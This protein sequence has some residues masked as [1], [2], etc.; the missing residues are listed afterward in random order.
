MESLG[1][2]TG[3][4]IIYDA[5]LVTGKNSPAV[6][7][8]YES[9]EVLQQL[10]AG[11]NLI[12]KQI[13]SGYTITK[14]TDGHYRVGTLALT[15]INGET[16]NI[17]ENTGSYT[18]K[19][20]ST[21]TK[22][23]LSIRETPQSV[24][25][26]TR[27]RMDDEN[28]TSLL[29]VID[30]TPGLSISYDGVG[31]PD[32]YSRGFTIDTTTEDGINNSFNSYVP[33]PLAN[34]A[35]YD[36]VE[37][38]RGA[39]GLAKGKGNPSGVVNL[40][41]KRP[42]D[43]FQASISVEF[44]SW[45]DLSATVD[46][47]GAITDDGKIK[48][49][50]VGYVQDADNF[51]DVEKN[52]TEMLYASVDFDYFPATHINVGYSYLNTFT[53][54]VWG[55]IP[56]SA[57]GKHLDLDRE[58]FIGADWDHLKQ[59][60]NTL[61]LNVEHSFNN[62]W[63]LYLNAKY[64]NTVSDV[65]GTWIMPED[66]GSGHGHIYW[67]AK[68]DTNQIAAD[69]YVA[70]DVTLFNRAHEVVIGASYNKEEVESASFFDCFD[71]SCAV[72]KITDLSTWDP[73]MATQ[74]ILDYADAPIDKASV[75]QKSTYAV[76]RWNISEQLKFISGGRLDWYE[77]IG[78]WSETKEDANLS[79][80]GG[81][82]YDFHQHHSAYVSYTDIFTPQSEI[83]IHQKVLAPIVGENYEL[84]VKGEYFDG[85]LNTNFSLFRIDQANKAKELLDQSACPT[86]PDNSCYD[87]SGLVRSKG[88]DIELQG[89]LTP[90]WQISAGYTY[91]SVEYVEDANHNNIGER[92]DTGVPESLFKFNTSYRLPGE[93]KHWKIAGGI[94][95]QS[96][97]FYDIAIDGNTVR[98]SQDAYALV[99]LM[100]A[101]QP[102]DK[103]TIQL[104]VDNVFDKKYYSAISND[105]T[106]GA[107]EMYGE[108]RNFMLSVK[109]KL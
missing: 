35:M 21:A 41:R 44:G 59:D 76:I 9:T 53:N 84:G 66:D 27:Q 71:T 56:I 79:L 36:R 73:S 23:G 85:L 81:L 52:E 95:Y 40:I 96:D 32:F 1:Q 34:L 18:T 63:G 39:A 20:M 94:H 103:L 48:A 12:T 68:D 107:L 87:T 3:L 105:V 46:V 58:T 28:M 99:N 74:P 86:F 55:G 60:V 33:S 17:T 2:Q 64:A 92:L 7:G 82:I 98:N 89:E 38:V 51:R 75:L 72:S 102:T 67:A 61:Y 47:S 69:L 37:V 54:M 97:I 80:Y 65:L 15:T 19:S 77:N 31:R 11:T 22:L 14:M 8:L 26:L 5:D 43:K 49:R 90:S 42:T 6:Q 88:I 30:N 100:V 4:Q 57:E 45:N 25:V 29:D 16:D 91:S 50:V 62:G 106:Y 108:P 101:Y 83:D 93:L 104:N 109:Y 24:T 13:S 78:G 70:G 10:L